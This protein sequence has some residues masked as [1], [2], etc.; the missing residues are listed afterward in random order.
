MDQ[1]VNDYDRYNGSSISS[2][3]DVFEPISS[4]N[5]KT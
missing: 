2:D 1:Q 3:S 4:N 5:G